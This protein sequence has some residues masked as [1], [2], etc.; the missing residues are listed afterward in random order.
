[1]SLGE[2]LRIPERKS[3]AACQPALKRAARDRHSHTA[4]SDC[5]L[6]YSG[7]STLDAKSYSKLCTLAMVQPTLYRYFPSPRPLKRPPS[8]TFLHLPFILR[9][10]IYLLAGLS[11][12]STIYLNYI[13]SSN[14]HCTQDYNPLV[15]EHW[16]VEPYITPRSHSLS[17]FLD[18]YLPQPQILL[19]RH[20]ECQDC[21][22]HASYNS[23]GAWIY[24]ACN[25]AP[26]PW[27]LLYVSKAIADE[28]FSI[29]YSEN[30]FSVFRN[31][32][33][34][35]SALSSLPKSA[36]LDMASLS[37]CLNYFEPEVSR[38][39]RSFG[40]VIQSCDIDCHAPCAASKQQRLFTKAKLHHEEASIKELQKLCQVL[41]H[42]QSQQLNL[43][44]TCD[45]SDTSIAE[46]VLHPL[47][48]LPCLRECSIRL[49]YLYLPDDKTD[50]TPIQHVAQEAVKKLTTPP[51]A[52]RKPFNF[53]ALP[54]EIQL[55]ILSHTSLVTPYDLV[56]GP[57][58]PIAKDIKTPFYE[59]R[60]FPWRAY[61]SNA[62]C[63]TACS[64]FPP[65]EPE[66]CFCWSSFAAFSST[67]TCFRFPLPLFLLNKSTKNIAEEIFYS[68]N[69][70][71]VLRRVYNPSRELEIYSFLAWI[72]ESARRRL[73]FLT[74][75]MS[76]GCMSDWG[77]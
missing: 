5:S 20:C 68:R 3:W 21:N 27:Q 4:T 9:R 69:H 17:H 15:P 26:L 59:P 60:T 53:P 25:C 19:N 28:V 36:L 46:E 64:P 32:L 7:P 45:V 8:K 6:E 40:P 73:R 55:Q 67:C 37:I 71:Q 13:P 35:L 43:S 47:F 1:M 70:F 58:T 62:E 23:N 63:C 57:N 16:P 14:E 10:E 51:P 18:S 77:R 31:S 56:W 11:T 52:A 24:T 54:L 22:S 76:W 34:G 12:N 74:W 38:K 29:F 50:Y 48:Q 49:G 33:C 72:P 2:A 65:L 41:T 30:H 42:I 75:E 66:I 61:P 39:T 44:F